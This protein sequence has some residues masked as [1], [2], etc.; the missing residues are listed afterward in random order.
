MYISWRQTELV[1]QPRKIT[2]NGITQ[3]ITDTCTFLP[4]ASITT[5]DLYS[6]YTHYCI[7]HGIIPAKLNPFARSFKYWAFHQGMVQGIMYTPVNYYHDMGKR[8]IVLKSG[9]S[10]FNMACNYY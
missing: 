5:D 4:N 9:W 10:Y 2:V 3:F 6:R 1:E 8:G 7:D